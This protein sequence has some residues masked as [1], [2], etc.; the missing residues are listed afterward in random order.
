MNDFAAI[1][2]GGGRAGEHCSG[3][4]PEGGLRVIYRSAATS[5]GLHSNDAVSRF[6]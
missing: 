4:L 2:I 1:V 6:H 5:N 3:A